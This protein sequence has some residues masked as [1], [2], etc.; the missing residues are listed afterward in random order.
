M[1]AYFVAKSMSVTDVP[2][3]K[4]GQ[5]NTT[6]PSYHKSSTGSNLCTAYSH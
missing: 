1:R 6:G 2:D 4:N 5:K 3:L